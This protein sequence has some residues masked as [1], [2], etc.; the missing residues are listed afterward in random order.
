MK[1]LHFIL[2]TLLLWSVQTTAQRPATLRQAQAYCDTTALDKIEG[3][4][5]MQADGV[6]VLVYRSHIS[7][8]SPYEIIVVNT[9]DASLPWG[10]PIGTLSPTGAPRQYTLTLYTKI[11]HNKPASPKTFTVT[12]NNEYSHL[13]IRKPDKGFRFTFSP[14]VLLPGLWRMFRVT[15]QHRPAEQITGMIKVY[16]INHADPSSPDFPFYF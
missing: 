3:I 1:K 7:P 12:T 10:F 13:L 6:Q 2:V 15:W 14:T 8:N 9:H 4:W 11:K 5:N 16:P